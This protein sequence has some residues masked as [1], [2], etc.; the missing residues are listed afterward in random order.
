MSGSRIEVRPSRRGRTITLVVVALVLLVLGIWYVNNPRSLPTSSRTVNAATIAGQ[1]VYVGVFVPGPD[2]DRTLHLS[3]VKVHTTA[4]TQ[5]EVVPLLCRGGSVAVTSEPEPFCEEL[6]NPEDQTFGAG[7]SIVLEVT[8][9]EDAIAVIDPVRLGF[10]EG[11]QWGTE[12]AGAGAI[13]T[14]RDR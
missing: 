13:V 4:N 12:R 8:A 6:V 3:G 1:P 2:F 9:D 5:V 7:D 10:R 14:V 11:L